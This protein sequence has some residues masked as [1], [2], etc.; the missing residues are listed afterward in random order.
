MLRSLK[1]PNVQSSR[2]QKNEKKTTQ[3]C[4]LPETRSQV[5]TRSLMQP[6]NVAE[7]TAALEREDNWNERDRLIMKAIIDSSDEG[8]LS[9]DYKSTSRG[10][11]YAR[12][13]AQ[14]QSCKKTI[15]TKALKGMGF[16]LDL[17]TSFPVIISGIV[18]ELVRERGAHAEMPETT[19][20]FRNLKV[21][22]QRAAQDLSTSV[23]IV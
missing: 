11:W 23:D 10:R 18:S 19:N 14:L 17:R 15:R 2:R 6:I 16:I 5:E 20:M 3:L 4:A 22:R 9:V 8:T 7:L 21:W 12:G 1:G 13:V